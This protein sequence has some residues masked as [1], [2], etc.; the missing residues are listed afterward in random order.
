MPQF[1][2]YAV[3]VAKWYFTLII[4]HTHS[5]FLPVDNSELESQFSIKTLYNE[6]PYFLG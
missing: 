4:K 6:G 5:V 3:Q 2:N 1:L